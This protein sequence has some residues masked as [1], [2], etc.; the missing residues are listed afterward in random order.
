MMAGALDRVAFLDRAVIAENHDADIV[1]FQVQRHAAQA[2]WKL[3]H[4]AGLHVVQAM[5]AGNPVA[6]RKDRAHFGDVC[7]GP[8]ALD[9][10]LED[11]GDFG[12]AD[13]HLCNPFHGQLH[14][15][16]LGAD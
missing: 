2:A 13:F 10:L 4:L 12:G 11:C 7:L 8:E 5:H 16:Q 15:E 9:L 14:L 1:R 6:D 3:H